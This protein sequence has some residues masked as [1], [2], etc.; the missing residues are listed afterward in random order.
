MKTSLLS[1]ASLLMLASGAFAQQG[2]KIYLDTKKFVNLDCSLQGGQGNPSPL[3]KIYAHTGVCT[4]NPTF[5]SGTITTTNSEVWQH[6]V[7]NWGSSPADD[8]VGEMTNEGNGIWS[9]RI[10][11]YNRYYGDSGIVNLGTSAGGTVTS[12][13]MQPGQTAYTM[14]LVFRSA[15]ASTSGRDN[16][17]NDIFITNLETNTPLI[18]GSSDPTLSEW[19]NAPISFKKVINGVEVGLPETRSFEYH[20][21]VYP[22]PFKD[23]TR[24]E[25]FVN[26]ASRNYSISVFDV[27]GRRVASVLEG[28]VKA[29]LN[30]LDWDGTNDAGE[31][32]NKGLYYFTINGGNQVASDKLIILD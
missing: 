8:G 28:K 21:K 27:N 22:N 23:E 17:C 11:N 20:S 4:T 32:L 29:G 3:P 12:T 6:V 25:F 7:G 24:I 18:I 31:K 15:D 2:L 26:D 16:G 13:P 1:L 9:L 19:I 30:T 14:G 5:C 10:N